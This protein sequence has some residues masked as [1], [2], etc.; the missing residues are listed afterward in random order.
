VCNNLSNGETMSMVNH[1]ILSLRRYVQFP[2]GFWASTSTLMVDHLQC[3]DIRDAFA[4]GHGRKVSSVGCRASHSERMEIRTVINVLPSPLTVS[5]VQRMTA[6]F[7]HSSD[8][9]LFLHASCRS[10]PSLHRSKI[11]CL[12]GNCGILYE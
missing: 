3:S 1:I 2:T 5:F 4:R 6:L 7:R 12:A 11:H 10:L 8:T 9:N